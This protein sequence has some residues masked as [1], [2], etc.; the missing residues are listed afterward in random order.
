MAEQKIT[1]GGFMLIDRFGHSSEVC[2][3]NAGG[4][5]TFLMSSP[6]FQTD[7]VCYQ[8]RIALSWL[9]DS[10]FCTVHPSSSITGSVFSCTYFSSS[11]MCNAPLPF[12]PFILMT[13]SHP[14]QPDHLNSS[15]N[16]TI[17]QSILKGVTLGKCFY[18]SPKFLFKLVSEFI[19]LKAK[20]SWIPT[21][22][23][24]NKSLLNLSCLFF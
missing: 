13:F 22:T 14:F 7:G 21:S 15:T 4:V 16:N 18:T 6:V 3:N 8:K 2:V 10:H 12:S 5:F 20:F 9:Y 1:A 19:G 23:S 24:E 11:Q 17:L